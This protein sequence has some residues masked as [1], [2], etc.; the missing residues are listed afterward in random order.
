MHFS[1]VST[2][3]TL[4]VKL[5]E[6]FWYQCSFQQ[7]YLVKPPQIIQPVA[8]LMFRVDVIQMFRPLVPIQICQAKLVLGLLLV[9]ATFLC[10]DICMI[11]IPSTLFSLNFWT[12]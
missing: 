3:T 2:S 1:I 8:L 6:M 12:G 11:Y 10:P 5:T 9:N 4:K 7:A